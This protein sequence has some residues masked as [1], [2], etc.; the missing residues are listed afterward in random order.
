M[1]M[2]MGGFFGIVCFII[3]P[4]NAERLLNSSELNLS[5]E[6]NPIDKK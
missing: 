3:D 5:P 2:S 4:V 1:G 6:W